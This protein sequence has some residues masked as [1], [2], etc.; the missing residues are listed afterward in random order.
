M[1]VIVSVCG[2]PVYGKAIPGVLSHDKN[3]EE[4]KSAVLFDLESE[5]NGWVNSV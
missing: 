4:G 5:L 2:F 1:Y 3:V